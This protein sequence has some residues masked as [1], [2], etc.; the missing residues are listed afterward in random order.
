MNLFQRASENLNPNHLGMT[1]AEYEEQL[2]RKR[3]Y[4]RLDALC[5]AIAPPRRDPKTGEW[6]S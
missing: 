2:R 6:M 1:N 5:K 4:D 3:G